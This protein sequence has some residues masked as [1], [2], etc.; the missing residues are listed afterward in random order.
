LNGFPDGA[1]LCTLQ[2]HRIR[3]G[4]AAGAGLAEDGAE[5]LCAASAYVVD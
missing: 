4:D 5:R 1:K 3:C 2:A